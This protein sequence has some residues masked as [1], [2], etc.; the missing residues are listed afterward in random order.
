MAMEPFIR[1]EGVAAPLPDDNIDTDIIFPA[2]FLLI[3]DRE[4][5]GDY[6][7][8]DRR[9]DSDGREVADFILNRP[10]WRHSP[11]LVT[12]ANFGCGSSREQAVWA[13]LGAGVRCLIAPGFG[14]I[15]EANCIRNGLLPITLDA[16]D[17]VPLMAAAHAGETLSID[18]ELLSIT[19]ANGQ[20]QRFAIREER[21]QAM[22]NGWDETAMILNSFGASIDRFEAAQQH[23]Q[24]WL[25]ARLQPKGTQP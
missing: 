6:A 25:Y 7:F 9:Y 21:R 20:K 24:P 16:A 1:L 2:R 15:F 19:R 13:L 3:T 22:L 11:I 8:R 17:I 12:G 4:G 14:E 10:P 18:L 23:V 5:L